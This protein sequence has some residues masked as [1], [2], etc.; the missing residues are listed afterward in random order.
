MN[1]DG[2]SLPDDLYVMADRLVQC[3]RVDDS[4]QVD[5]VYDATLITLY[6][7]AG[8]DDRTEPQ[9]SGGSCGASSGGCSS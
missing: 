2:S 9:G 8:T 6:G 3:D 1:A 5:D 7:M 4:K